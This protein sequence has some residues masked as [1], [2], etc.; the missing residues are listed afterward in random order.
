MHEGG[1]ALPPA[2][3]YPDSF[4]LTRR[5]WWDGAAWTA[6]VAPLEAAAPAVAVLDRPATLSSFDSARL[7]AG[8]DVTRSAP[9]GHTGMMAPGDYASNPLRLGSPH[10]LPAW[11]IALSPLWYAGVG[12]LVGF[13]S[14]LLVPGVNRELL[15][16]P[17]LV[18][19]ALI[20]FAF[21]RVDRSRLYDRNYRPVAPA[22][23]LLPIVYL[24]I[25]TVRTGWRGAGLLVTHILLQLLFLAVIALAVYAILAAMNPTLLP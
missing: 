25:R 6:H 16:G 10:T 23:A 11:F 13:V 8:Y 2:G 12:I 5:R 18:A 15:A 22:W 9:A 3:W 24:I 7:A 1:A 14:S 19:F 21:A 4:D 17:S 20:L